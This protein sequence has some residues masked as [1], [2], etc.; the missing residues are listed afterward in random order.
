MQKVSRSDDPKPSVQL[1]SGRFYKPHH[2]W[3]FQTRE[4]V[5]AGPFDSRE[6]AESGSLEYIK[7]VQ[8]ATAEAM[9][10]LSARAS[11]A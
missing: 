4:G 1:R 9:S 3:F 10:M 5:S 2:F 6:A 7:F 8:S 11:A